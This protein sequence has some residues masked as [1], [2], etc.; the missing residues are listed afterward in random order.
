MS[1]ARELQA[2]IAT[3]RAG[4]EVPRRIEFVSSLPTGDEIREQLVNRPI[5]LDAPS[6]E[7]RWI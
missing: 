1:F 5:R 4:H 7:D 6:P 3:R 2:L